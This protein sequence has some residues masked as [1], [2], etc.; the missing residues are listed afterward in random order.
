MG[1]LCLACSRVVSTIA[2]KCESL[3]NADKI[4]TLSRLHRKDG[5][6]NESKSFMTFECEY[7]FATNRGTQVPC[8][9]S[10]SDDMA[11]LESL[12]ACCA[13]RSDFAPM[14]QFVHVRTSNLQ[15]NF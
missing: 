15:V 13:F 9:G 11:A 12:G 8:T 6:F 1:L 2:H 14:F 7:L 5:T 10:E 3:R 4:K